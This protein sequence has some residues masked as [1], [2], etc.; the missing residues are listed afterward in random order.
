MAEL[1]PVYS[2]VLT[3]E[4]PPAE[5]ELLE[6]LCCKITTKSEGDLLHFQCTKIDTSHFNYIQM[7][8]FKTGDKDTHPIQVQ[9][10]YVLLISGSESHP[11]IGF[12]TNV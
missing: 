10:R 9:H 4:L 12:V 8:T 1:T 2:V 3:S 11:S 7:E 5:R 6:H